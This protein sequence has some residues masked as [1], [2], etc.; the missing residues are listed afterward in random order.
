M[1]LNNNNNNSKAIM[2]LASMI[3]LRGKAL[4]KLQQAKNRLSIMKEL[5]NL[6][7]ISIVVM[8]Y[9]MEVDH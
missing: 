1:D 6:E 2:S 9:I 5:L 4:N 7:K 3:N 8:I